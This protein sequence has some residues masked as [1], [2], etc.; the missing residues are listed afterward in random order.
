MTDIWQVIYY[1]ATME[2]KILHIGDTVILQ[3][4]HYNG[5]E[6]IS[7]NSVNL[8]ASSS[9]IENIQELINENTVN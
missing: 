3:N 6:I 9:L 8:K 4:I 5:G 2:T 7:T 1:N